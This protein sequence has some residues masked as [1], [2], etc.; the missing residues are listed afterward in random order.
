MTL[1]GRSPGRSRRAVRRAAPADAGAVRPAE[2]LFRATR[3]TPLFTGDNGIPLIRYHIADNGGLIGYDELLAFL[4]GHGF[5]R[6]RP[7]GR[8]AARRLPFVYVFG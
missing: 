1:A 4:A 3:G 2:P 6:W 8:R 5:D 7:G